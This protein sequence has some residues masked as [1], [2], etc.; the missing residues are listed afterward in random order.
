MVLV[1]KDQEA[2][3]RYVDLAADIIA[4]AKQHVPKIFVHVIGRHRLSNVRDSAADI[5]YTEI[6]NSSVWREMSVVKLSGPLPLLVVVKK[7][8]QD[9]VPVGTLV[10]FTFV[11][12]SNAAEW[13]EFTP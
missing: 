13:I 6:R 2:E 12:R 3:D 11:K 1:K 7:V 9:K 8:G 5:I 10:E 4:K